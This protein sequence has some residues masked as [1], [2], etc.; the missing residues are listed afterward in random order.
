MQLLRCRA[1]QG[2]GQVMGG[3]MIYHD[4]EACD[5]DGKIEKPEDEISYLQVKQ[6]ETYQEA[7][8]EIKSLDP[9]MNDSEADK[10]LKKQFDK[11]RDRI[12]K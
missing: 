10:L 7:I 12:K 5:G 9:K 1:C 11:R 8:D 6:S 3:G 2:S 4:C